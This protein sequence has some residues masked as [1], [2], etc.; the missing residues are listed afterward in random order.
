MFGICEKVIV[1]GNDYNIKDGMCIRDYIYVIDFC[2]VYLKVIE[3]LE[4]N[5]KSEIFNLG[6]G[7]GFLVME[8]IEKVSEVVGK[9]ILYEIG[10]RRVGDFLILVVLL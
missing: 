4:K 10:L 5:N 7:M 8:V 9:K 1:Y 3:Y 6:N 2:D